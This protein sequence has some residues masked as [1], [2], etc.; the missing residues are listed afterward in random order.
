MVLSGFT[1]PVYIAGRL[2]LW[3]IDD[4]LTEFLAR[5]IWPSTS[6]DVLEVLHAMRLTALVPLRIRRMGSLCNA[7]LAMLG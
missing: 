1:A 3:M 7:L 5:T 4:C 2:L 6:T